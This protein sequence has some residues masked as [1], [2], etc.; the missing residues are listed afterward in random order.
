MSSF[1]LTHQ[2]LARAIL[3]TRKPLLNNSLSRGFCAVQTVC[4]RPSLSSYK[5]RSAYS[6]FR[7]TGQSQ[8]HTRIGGLMH[9]DFEWQDP[10][11]DDEVVNVTIVLRD[12]TEKVLRGKVGDNLLYLCHRFDVP[13]EGACEASLACSTC[14]VYVD[15]D[16]L[17]LLDEA[18]EEEED[19]LDMAVF[20]KEN[21]RLGCQIKLRKDLEGLKVELPKATRNF[22]VDGHVPTP[23]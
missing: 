20:L 12:G 19:M 6:V 4:Y 15:E 7:H 23:H 3:H 9:G 21:S 16:Y 8:F 10:K 14:H 17:D 18:E 1:M 11:S 2:R 22:Y 13:M 5:L